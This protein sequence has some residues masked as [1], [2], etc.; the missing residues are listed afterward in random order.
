M[1]KCYIIDD[2]S[3]A[4]ETL[5][6]YAE[7]SGQLE[8]IGTSQNP[9]EAVKYINQYKNIDITFLDID[10]PEI[11]GLDVADLIYD[12]TAIIFTTGHAGYAVE[13]FEKSISDF[14]LKPIS[15][16]RFMKSLNKVIA[17]LEKNEQEDIKNDNYFFV[18]PGIKGKMLKINY[19]DVDYIEALN[20]Y[21][22]I[23]TPLANH[24]IYLTMKE[25]EAGLPPQFIRV[26]KSYILN[27]DK[28]TLMEGN[29]IMVNKLVFP[30]GSSYK[31]KLLNKINNNIIKS[32][33]S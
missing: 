23:H 5:K 25:I 16:P 20:N 29:K 21:I 30:L 9:L 4:I 24:I 15:F 11:S 10:M 19:N 1:Y 13:G 31:E 2:E 32:H 17:I 22:V 27:I 12:Y 7:E 26:H 33:R 6:K 28:V 18:N 3:H 8:V 14:M